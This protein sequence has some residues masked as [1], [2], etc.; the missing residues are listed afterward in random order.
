MAVQDRTPKMATLARHLVS[1][2]RDI[3]K[4]LRNQTEAINEA[5][6][7]KQS[8][9][10]EVRAEVTT[11]H[12]VETHK[13]A[14]D[15]RDDQGY[16]RRTLL[17]S[18]LTL[19]A[20]VIYSVLVFFQ[21]RELKKATTATQNAAAAATSAAN[22]ADQT[23]KNAKQSFQIDQRPYL[24]AESPEF[25]VQPAAPGGVPSANVTF[26]NIGRT[27]AVRMKSQIALLRFYP[28]KLTPKGTEKIVR[29]MQDNFQVLENAIAL[30]DKGK[31]SELI[32]ED[33]A[34]NATTFSTAT[35]AEPITAEDIFK[36]QKGG[37]MTLFY[38]GVVK[39]TDAY[40]GSYETE[41]CFFYFGT[42]PKTWHICD[43]HNI[44]Q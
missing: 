42:D 27:P 43:N 41:F 4:S 6:K 17:V 10:S 40:N 26:K 11:P 34:P 31:Y 28:A 5:N 33:L 12:G 32:R 30:G 38:I 44:I 13:S 15:A 9:P 18:W 35:L 24:I 36:L 14:T 21:W 19:A 22:T 29:F 1:A 37:L 3:G 25:V 39:Y 2:I 7:T 16:Q 8:P 20:I 23:L